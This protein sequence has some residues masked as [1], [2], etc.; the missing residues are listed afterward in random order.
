VLQFNMTEDIRVC[1]RSAQEKLKVLW[2]KR[3]PLSCETFFL[4]DCRLKISTPGPCHCTATKW[5]SCW[6][7]R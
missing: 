1:V 6:T 5:P 3:D 2:W 7:S 4:L